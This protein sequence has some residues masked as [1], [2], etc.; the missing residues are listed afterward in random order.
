MIKSIFLF[1]VCSIFLSGCFIKEK[2]G[3]L[4]QEQISSARIKNL[5]QFEGTYANTPQG[6]GPALSQIIFQSYLPDTESI[7][8][9]VL[10]EKQILVQALGKGRVIMEKT[11][12]LEKDFKISSSKIPLESKTKSATYHGGNE[13]AWATPPFTG[14]GHISGNLFINSNGDVVYHHSDKV[15]MLILFV[16]PVVSLNDDYAL[17]KKLK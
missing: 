2:K 16:I 13:N 11:L 10:D 6:N 8:C 12:F 5:K 9:K 7:S 14:I 15:A 4:S 17:Y 3:R 1:V